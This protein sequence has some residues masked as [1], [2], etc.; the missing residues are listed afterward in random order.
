MCANH[1]ASGAKIDHAAAA[2]LASLPDARSGANNVAIRM[3]SYY[4]D[5]KEESVP[6]L[7][8]LLGDPEPAMRHLARWA[9]DG[10]GEKYERPAARQDE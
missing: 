7:R 1:S 3:L 8:M 5:H 6:R 10:L 4:R 9:L 2:L